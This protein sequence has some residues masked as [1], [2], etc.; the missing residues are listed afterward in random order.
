MA[1]TL[2]EKHARLFERVCQIETL[3][4][5]QDVQ[6]HTTNLRERLG[7][8]YA[9][10]EEQFSNEEAMLYALLNHRDTS[11]REAAR[12]RSDTIESIMGGIANYVRQLDK[13]DNTKSDSE[14]LARVLYEVLDLLTECVATEDCRVRF[15]TPP[16]KM[17][18]FCKPLRR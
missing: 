4:R 11:V 13:G 15:K 1:P 17:A 2:R 10:F 9:E 12:L 3:L 6:S 18:R 14:Q 16:T 7:A 8:L 5:S